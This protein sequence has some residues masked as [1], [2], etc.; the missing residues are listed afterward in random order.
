MDFRAHLLCFWLRFLARP[1]FGHCPKCSSCFGLGCRN[2]LHVIG[3]CCLHWCTISGLRLVRIIS[4]SEQ[5]LDWGS[6]LVG[7][8]TLVMALQ[9]FAQLTAPRGN[10]FSHGAIFCRHPRFVYWYT[11][12]AETQKLDYNFW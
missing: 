12:T 7:T 4:K 2:P 6:A 3:W 1:G 9:A 5:E 11:L 8:I 10:A